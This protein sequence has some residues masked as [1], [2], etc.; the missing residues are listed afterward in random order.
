MTLGQ[1]A[2]GAAP[3]SLA[4]IGGD[5]T[6][7]RQVQDRF[8]VVGLLDPPSDGN[9]GP[10]SLWAIAQFLRAIDR[11]GATVVD[12]PAARALVADDAARVFP[13]N[14]AGSFAGRIVRA[15]GAKGY[16]LCR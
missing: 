16:W 4:L 8:V 15:L 12:A 5:N 10:A 2:D 14:A 11:P 1:I 7:A 3:V 13:V 6:L 9:F